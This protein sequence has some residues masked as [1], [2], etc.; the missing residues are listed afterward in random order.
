MDAN[1]TYFLS[2]VT[3]FIVFCTSTLWMV[4]LMRFSKYT[5]TVSGLYLYDVSCGIRSAKRSH[6]ISYTLDVEKKRLKKI[7]IV[8]VMIARFIR[9]NKLTC[10]Y[11]AVA[12]ES[13]IF[14][15]LDS[16]KWPAI[17]AFHRPRFEWGILQVEHML[18]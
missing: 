5:F 1:K 18:V 3:S 11:H 8:S 10:C 17:E 15:I 4:A 14:R 9:H 13:H 6:R 16:K 7:F 2:A 12:V